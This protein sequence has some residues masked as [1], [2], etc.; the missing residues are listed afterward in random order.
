MQ[1]RNGYL[2][3]I[4]FAALEGKTDKLCRLLMKRPH[5]VNIQDRYG[6]TPLHYAAFHGQLGSAKILL[7][8]GANINQADGDGYPPI[9]YAKPR[10]KHFLQRRGAKQ[11][12]PF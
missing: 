3:S 4:H 8:W 9:Y 2:S 5:C 7:Q 6:M 11:F 12:D 10:I 1:T